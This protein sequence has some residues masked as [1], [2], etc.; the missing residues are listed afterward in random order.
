MTVN[1][2]RMDIGWLIRAAHANHVRSDDP[3][4]GCDNERDHLSIEVRPVG[5]AVK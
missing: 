4:T 3:V 2:V 5:L 1:S